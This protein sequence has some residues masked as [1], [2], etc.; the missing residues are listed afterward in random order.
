MCFPHFYRQYLTF[1]SFCYCKKQIDA[2]VLS[3]VLLLMIK[4]HHNIVI[5]LWIHNKFWQ[6]YDV[7]LSSIRGQTIKNWRQ[8]VFYSN[9]SSK[10]S[11]IA[12]KNEE[13]TRKFK[14]FLNYNVIVNNFCLLVFGFWWEVTEFLWLK[15]WQLE[16]HHCPE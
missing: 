11:N 9:K 1:S 12:G 8:F 13:N 4:W 6:Y 7:I 14:T 10:K 3:F 16:S 15:V 5:V 2:S